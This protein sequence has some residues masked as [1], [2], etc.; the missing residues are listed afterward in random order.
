ME[1]VVGLLIVTVRLVSDSRFRV[2]CSVGVG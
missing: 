1:K 2:S